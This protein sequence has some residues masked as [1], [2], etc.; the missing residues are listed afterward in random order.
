MLIKLRDKSNYQELALSLRLIYYGR[1]D[2]LKQ[3]GI[4]TT[5]GNNY[6]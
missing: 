4:K 3:N 2:L 5:K 6:D 1:L